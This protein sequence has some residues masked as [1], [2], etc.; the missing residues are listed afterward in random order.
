[1]NQAVF[2]NYG[3]CEYYAIE[4]YPSVFGSSILFV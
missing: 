3:W 1:M 4:L 2:L